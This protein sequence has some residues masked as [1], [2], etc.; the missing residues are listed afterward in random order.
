MLTRVVACLGS[1]WL[2]LSWA[3]HPSSC[4]MNAGLSQPMAVD[5]APGT[6]MVCCTCIEVVERTQERDQYSY[7][8]NHCPNLLLVTS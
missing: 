5:G 7:N 3:G 1:V 8:I 6:H 2:Q 4:K